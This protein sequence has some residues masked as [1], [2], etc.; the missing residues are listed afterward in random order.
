MAY[1]VTGSPAEPF[2]DAFL[3]RLLAT[4]A[5]TALV[6]TRI[7][8]ALKAG[9]KTALPYVLGGRRDVLPGSVAMQKEGGEV[10]I[11]IDVWSEANG[12]H[13]AHQILSAIRAAMGRDVVLTI[14]GFTMYAGSLACDE[15]R[16][17]QDDDTDM[18]QKSVWH[19]VQRWTADLEVED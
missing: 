3:D 6:G 16:V 12:P 8:A 5:V 18:P 11:W 4:S 2:A 1:A 17:F 13:E 19:G 9:V 7:S 15:E 14:D 10:A